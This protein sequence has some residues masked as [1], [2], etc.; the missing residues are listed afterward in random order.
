MLSKKLK[1]QRIGQ[2]IFNF[3]EWLEKKGYSDNL[4]S[5]RMA[6]PFNISDGNMNKLYEE[7][8]KEN[9]EK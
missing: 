4:Q 7:F 5:K 3:L 2:T 8:L 9:D 6:D 1:H